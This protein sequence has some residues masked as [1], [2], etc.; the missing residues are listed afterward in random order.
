[1]TVAV[2]IVV[3][4]AVFISY[5]SYL[6]RTVAVTIVVVCV[7]SVSYLYLSLPLQDVRGDHCGGL[8]SLY[9]LP[10]PFLPLQDGGGDHCGGLCRG[11]YPV[12]GPLLLLLSEETGDP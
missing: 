9:I 7:V 2:T 6:Y 10:L 11:D 1:M 4:C 5:L 12:Y 8:C 3:V